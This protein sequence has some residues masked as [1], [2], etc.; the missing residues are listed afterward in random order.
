MSKI[1]L[2]AKEKENKLLAKIEEDK[3]KLIALQEKRKH[4]IGSLAYKH[5]LH[6][7]DNELLEKAFA[8]LSAEFSHGHSQ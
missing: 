1:K 5:G 6:D 2:S 8:K 3:K 7:L 4:E